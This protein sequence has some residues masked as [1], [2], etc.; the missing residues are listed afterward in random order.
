[1]L[2]Q[3]KWLYLLAIDKLKAH[4]YSV[5]DR[6]SCPSLVIGWVLKKKLEKE[7]KNLKNSLPVDNEE[8]Y[9][10]QSPGM[11]VYILPLSKISMHK[12]LKIFTNFFHEP[13]IFQ[14]VYS[15]VDIFQADRKQFCFIWQFTAQFFQPIYWGQK[16]VRAL[17]IKLINTLIIIINNWEK[18][19]KI[20]NLLKISP[21]L[22]LVK[23]S[24][25]NVTIK[26]N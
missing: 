12:S 5:S 22:N 17:N 14:I 15:A 26:L 23:I 20:P 24:I 18:K 7:N 19:S 11:Q 8:F 25:K 1:V 10:H 4:F 21:Q 9:Q 16:L 13:F 6:L 3:W 2:R